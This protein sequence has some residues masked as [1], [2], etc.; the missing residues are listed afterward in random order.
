MSKTPLKLS[1]FPARP[2]Y[3]Q[4]GRAIKVKANFFEV[5]QL[6]DSNAYQYDIDI[7]PEV[8]PA[9]NRKVFKF[10]QESE[11]GGILGGVKPVYDGRRNVYTIKQFPFGDNVSAQV[12]LPEDD[13]VQV[14]K[15]PPRHFNLKLKKVAEKNMEEANRFV[16]GKSAS[17][18]NILTAI[19]ALDV[20]INQ[21]PALNFTSVG[22]RAFYT[23]EGSAPLY[24]G[25]EVWQG[26]WQSLRPGQGRF[27]INFDTSATAFHEPG[28]IAEIFVKI[29][30]FR[31]VEELRGL[32]DKDRIKI[33]KTLKQLKFQVVHRGEN[34]RRRFKVKRLSERPASEMTFSKGEG[35]KPINVTQY[36]Q[37]QYNRK[38][39]YPFL[40]CVVT[41][42]ETFFPAEVCYLE[43]GQRITRKLSDKQTA[44]MIKFTCQA[45]P[46]RADKIQKGMELLKYDENEYCKQWGLKISP[47]MV[48]LDARILPPPRLAYHPSCNESNFAPHAGSWQLGPGKKMLHGA[49]LQS[50]AVIIFASTHQI[51]KEVVEVF[52]RELI[53]TL[54][55]NGMNITNPHPKILHANPQGNIESTIRQAYQTAGNQTQQKPQLLLCILQARSTLYDEIKRVE[56]TVLGVPTQCAMGK[57]ILRAN[58]QYYGMLGLKINVKLQGSNM[59]LQPGYLP[60]LEKAPTIIFGADVTHPG[61]GDNS[62]SIAAL[63][64]SYDPKATKY[65]TSIRF[66]ASRME[67]I[68]PLQEMVQ[69]LLKIFFKETRRKPA[70]ILF[71]RDGVSEGQFEEVL[72]FEVEAIRKACLALEAS[73]KPTITFIIV[74]KRHHARFF[75]LD[76]KDSDKSQN[77]LPGTIVEKVIT[78]PFEYDFYLQSHPGLQGTSRPT[79]YH[80]VIDENKFSP[81][82]LQSL[83]YNLCYLYARCPRAVSVVPPAYYAHLAAFR[84]RC[85]RKAV[86]LPEN[87][88]SVDIGTTPEDYNSLKP[89]L[90]KLNMELEKPTTQEQVKSKLTKRELKELTRLT[91]LVVREEEQAN[92]YKEKAREN[93]K[94]P[95][96]DSRDVYR[97]L[98][99]KYTPYES[100]ACAKPLYEENMKLMQMP[101][102]NE[103]AYMSII[104]GRESFEPQL[105]YFCNPSV[106]AQIFDEHLS[107]EICALV[108]QVNSD[109]TKNINSRTE[110]KP[111]DD[112]WMDGMQK[113]Y[114]KLLTQN[115]LCELLGAIGILFN[116]KNNCG[117]PSKSETKRK[118]EMDFTWRNVLDA[119][120]LLHLPQSV[121]EASFQRVAELYDCS[122][123]HMGRSYILHEQHRRVNQ[124]HYIDELSTQKSV[125]PKIQ[126]VSET[127]KGPPEEIQ[128]VDKLGKR[129]RVQKKGLIRE[130]DKINEQ[131]SNGCE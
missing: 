44:D 50:W 91:Q 19:T 47:R 76:R 92:N 56:D 45:P 5:L 99:V 11:R 35:E 53:K 79:H 39:Q 32:S 95:S 130:I 129:V 1:E 97:S 22:R 3:G 54:G 117:M 36:F 17:S 122:K 2:G 51:R 106:F 42:N 4:A 28:N 24:G 60:F 70:R 105:G 67:I 52:I 104:T 94:W 65:A 29:L 78:H 90:Q 10:F 7:S 81:D 59:S 49:S 88:G 120:L 127:E 43:R 13:G 46:T 87:S 80:V 9:L 85:W 12:T 48:H 37:Q 57:K 25:A 64:G 115:F 71:Y 16:K 111:I 109:F 86:A 128:K 114:T 41:P 6:P 89:E 110:Y 21:V 118:L 93:I 73:Y 18:N 116:K 34:F 62:P 126:E 26:Y 121:H 103:T 84:A 66:Q 123:Q 8:P 72:K 68:S 113:H 75:P 101:A 100:L 33:E 15:R 102:I 61:L 23:S 55:E 27:F 63:V 98:P 14:V 124:L 112:D 31:R 125:A 74:Q 58:K 83:T 107:Q 20:L 82:N 131:L 38:L 30:G 119:S 40:P 96:K 69:E 108:D 77:C